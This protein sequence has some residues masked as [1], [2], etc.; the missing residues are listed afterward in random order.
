MHVNIGCKEKTRPDTIHH[1]GST[2]LCAYTLPH[3]GNDQ[4]VHTG[5]QFHLKVYRPACLRKWTGPWYI[6]RSYLIANGEDL[7]GF[8]EAV[9][10]QWHCGVYT[11]RMKHPVQPMNGSHTTKQAKESFWSWPWGRG[12]KRA[13][14]GIQPSMST[15]VQSSVSHT[16]YFHAHAP[17][18]YR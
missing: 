11:R 9:Y 18:R 13:D 2:S 7:S 6:K 16:C 4:T 15:Q 14:D 12:V 5:M 8:W 1:P 3:L 17:Q 10:S